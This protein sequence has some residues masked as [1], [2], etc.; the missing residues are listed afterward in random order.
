LRLLAARRSGISRVGFRRV[1]IR[2]LARG[3]GAQPRDAALQRGKQIRTGPPQMTTRGSDGTAVSARSGGTTKPASNSGSTRGRAV[4]VRVQEHRRLRR[5]LRC[6]AG[7][8]RHPREDGLVHLGEVA[9]DRPQRPGG[10]WDCAPAPHGIGHPS[11]ADG[12][13]GRAVELD[14]PSDPDRRGR[15]PE[16]QVFNG[17]LIPMRRSSRSAP[18]VTCLLGSALSRSTRGRCSIR[19]MSSMFL[20]CST[21][22]ISAGITR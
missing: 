3:A 6:W 16:I 1:C 5:R 22:S 10:P 8:V 9:R 15:R 18:T 12:A 11:D 19:G 17:F 13:R 21:P 4:L 7:N 2:I 20:R 14:G